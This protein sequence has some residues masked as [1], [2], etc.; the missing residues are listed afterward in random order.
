[1]HSSERVPHTIADILRDTL[2]QLEAATDI[3]K[4]EAALIE[5]RIHLLRT[6]RGLEPPKEI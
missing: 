1:M 4:D 6:L 5:L 2:R 3:R